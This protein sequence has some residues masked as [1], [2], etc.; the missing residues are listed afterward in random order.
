MKLAVLGAGKIVNE[1]LPEA[2]KIPGLELAAIYGRRREVLEPIA[3]EFGIP[4]VYTDVDEC[5]ADPGIDTVW[6]AVPNTL[7]FEFSRAALL[8][9]KNVICEK[10]FV[11]ESAQL[12]T[13]AELARERGL[14][15]VEAI[16]TVH[17]ESFGYLRDLLPS[18]GTLKLLSSEYAQ[19]SS[20]MD[21][22]RAGE[23]LH[24]SFD[25]AHGGGSLMDL[26]VYAVHVIVG[27]L[28]E[29]K[30][31][32][33]APNIERGTDTSGVLTL[34]YPETTAIA[35]FGKDC[36]GPNR[37]ILRGL[38]GYALCSAPPNEL[39]GVVHRTRGEEEQVWEPAPQS[40]RMIAEFV[41]FERLI[42]EGDL[43][44]RDRLLE[45]SA[46]VVGV[47]EAARRSL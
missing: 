22:F 30:A 38:D 6:V 13:L 26:G 16:T 10:P 44:A 12:E 47:L 20:R 29:P 24:P 35:V 40:H 42:R 5:L 39:S 7:H 17:S 15:L 45:H 9:G 46:I 3:E 21:A 28:G 31:I 41:E 2:K 14:I 32:S 25:P 18:L 8:A 23:P 36:D 43:A 11:L 37:T 33:Y 27:L 1:F 34:E 19:Y 4:R